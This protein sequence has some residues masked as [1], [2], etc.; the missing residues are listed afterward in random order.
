MQ[1][2]RD[3]DINDLEVSQ[4][5]EVAMRLYESRIASFQVPH[6]HTE[7]TN[8]RTE[9]TN[10]HTPNT[11]RLNESPSRRSRFEMPVALGLGFRVWGFR[12]SRRSRF[13]MPVALGVRCMC[14]RVR[15]CVCT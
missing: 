9:Q 7:H 1:K 5:Q 10:T 12:V 2:E 6:T 3:D 15:V 8:T 11:Q 14:V 13:E 4:K